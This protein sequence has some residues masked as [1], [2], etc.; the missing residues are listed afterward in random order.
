M[1]QKLVS[2]AIAAMMFAGV[3][4]V[5]AQEKSDFKT[6]TGI[7]LGEYYKTYHSRV[8]VVDENIQ[9]IPAAK[10]Q[11]GTKSTKALA[12]PDNFW[13]PGEF[14]E[15]QAVLITWSYVH[16]DLSGRYYDVEP[17]NETQGYRR[18]TGRVV[19]YKSVIDTSSDTR[20]PII[21][22]KLAS[23]IQK[24]GAQVWINICNAEDSLIVKDYMKV[25]G[26]DLENYRF[27]VNPQNSFWYRDCGPIAFYQGNNDEL[28]FLDFEYYP[29]RAVDDEI[30]IHVAEEMN[31]PVYTTS[32]ELEGGNVILDGLG[33]LFTSDQLYAANQDKGGQYYISNGTLYNTTKDTLTKN[34]IHDSLSHLFGLNRLE[35]LPALQYDGGTGHIDLYAAMWDENN[36]VFTQYPNEMNTFVDYSIASKNIDSILSLHSYHQK[37]YR[38]RNIPLPKR[39]DDTWYQSDSTYA[40]YTR[41][42]S[43]SLFVNNVIITPVFSDTSWGAREWD[44]KAISLMQEQFPG[45]EIIPIDIRGYKGYSGTGFDGSGGAIHCITKQ[46]PAENPVRILHNA[47]QDYANDYLGEFPIS[48]T[49]TNKSGIASAT[50]YWRVK[51]E[52]E[53]TSLLLEEKADNE[54][55]AILSRDANINID[56]IEYYISATSTNGKTITKPFTAPKGYYSFYYGTDATPE[57]TEE[58][59]AVMDTIAPAANMTEGTDFEPIPRPVGITNIAK[60]DIAVGNFYPNPAKETAQILISD[61]NQKQ[62]QVQVVNVSGQTVYAN[63]FTP[64]SNQV[65]FQLKVSS[66][67]TGVYTVI[68]SDNTGKS[69]AKKLIVQ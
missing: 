20:L 9:S 30:P 4:L 17:V 37:K 65:V 49:I 1:N 52:T 7:S 6:K 23:A 27:F 14:E 62:M 18:S 66:F 28:A 58:I 33:T 19:S 31:I 10:K 11:G 43:N 64:Y 45:Y 16:W 21:F 34:Q 36:F 5:R 54:F 42:Y 38:G 29:G 24:G 2:I 8:P 41:T 56:T 55:S 59:Y 44:L 57:E 47:I 12:M 48:A 53:W 51:G 15:V 67:Q 22:A 61:M 69:V 39:D 68:F 50:C 46:I 40:T 3:G 13:F 26:Y 35:I 32:F 63:T 60:E 25:T